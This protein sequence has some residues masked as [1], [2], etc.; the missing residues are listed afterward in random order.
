MNLRRTVTCCASPLM[1]IYAYFI[2]LILYLV[3]INYIIKCLE[4]TRLQRIFYL[5]N[6]VFIASDNSMCPGSTQPLKNEYQDTPGSKD[7]RCV[8]LITY[9]LQVPMSRNLEALTSQ[10]P[11]GPI[12][13]YWE[14]FTFTF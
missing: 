13:L 11:L 1:Y 9:H 2:V 8:R 3:Y 6:T 12:C 14:Y 10:N 4:A 7:G 5:N